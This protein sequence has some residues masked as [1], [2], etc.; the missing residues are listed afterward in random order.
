M[1]DPR[2]AV[3]VEAFQFL[4]VG[5][6]VGQLDGW[7]VGRSVGWSV[8]L[9]FLGTSANFGVFGYFGYFWVLWRCFWGTLGYFKKNWYFLVLFGNLGIF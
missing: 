1:P 7:S 5:W 9:V 2:S 6:L 4:S 8:I 3:H